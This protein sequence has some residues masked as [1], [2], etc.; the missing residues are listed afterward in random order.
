MEHVKIGRG[1]QNQNVFS[2]HGRLYTNSNGLM[3]KKTEKDNIHVYMKTTKWYIIHT[4]SKL[5]NKGAWIARSCLRSIW[6]SSMF[7]GCKFRFTQ[8]Y[9]QQISN[10]KHIFWQVFFFQAMIQ[11]F[12]GW[13]KNICIPENSRNHS[14]FMLFFNQGNKEG[15]IQQSL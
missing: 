5:V 1:T 4:W 3:L 13:A 6:R 14:T 11:S 2:C 9:K 12:S 10:V 7:T 8:K 15:I